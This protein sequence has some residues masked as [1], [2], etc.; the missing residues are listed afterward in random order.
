MTLGHP[1]V[2]AAIDDLRLTPTDLKAFRVLWSELDF[3]TF[4]EKK[5]VVLGV[6][7]ACDRSHASRS[8]QKLV[9]FEYL[10][11]GP[12]S[13]RGVGTYRLKARVQ[14]PHTSADARRNRRQISSGL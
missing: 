12:R 1:L 8:L 9:E 6:Q 2:D 4:V 13:E 3:R 7:I 14:N 10:E 5:A 11:E